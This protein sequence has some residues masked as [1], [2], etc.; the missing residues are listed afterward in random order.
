M[1]G[2][3]IWNLTPIFPVNT[4]WHSLSISPFRTSS[5]SPNFS[6]NLLSSWPIFP[7]SANFLRELKKSVAELFGIGRAIDENSPSYARIVNARNFER[8]NQL[9]QDAIERGATL[10]MSGLV[11]RESHFIHPVILSN[12]APGSRI[13]EEEIFGP[14]LPVISFKSIEEVLGIINR[15]PKPLALY[16]FSN[17]GSFRKAILSQT[18]AGGVCI[19]D[20]IM[21]FTHSNLPFG[22]VNN[23]GM[24]KSH[25]RFGFLA[26]SNEKCIKTK[27]RI[28]FAL[29]AISSI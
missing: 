17:R 29:F 22:G 8:L 9:L 24:G 19:N 23:S 26:F 2:V 10:E 21:Q 16:I 27:G 13:M 25:G 7:S 3:F 15:K 18:S 4:C 11:N 1:A 6:A 5:F 14:L 20:C 12:V 28:F